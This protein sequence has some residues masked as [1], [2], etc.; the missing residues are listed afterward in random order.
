[1]KRDLSQV[2]EVLLLPK[3]GSEQV[4]LIDVL[5][6]AFDRIGQLAAEDQSTS[7]LTVRLMDASGRCLL[8][9]T[10]IF[11]E[12]RWKGQTESGEL[13]SADGLPFPWFL[14]LEDSSGRT[15]KIR[16][17]LDSQAKTM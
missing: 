1:M 11:Q 7:P 17:D 5:K 15:R 9:M 4:T 8:V 14:V 10:M 12:G 3:A 2:D 16:V 13:D 6:R